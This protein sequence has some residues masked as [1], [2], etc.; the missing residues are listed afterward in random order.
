MK[1][2]IIIIIIFLLALSPV[3][4]AQLGDWRLFHYKFPF[5]KEKV[6]Y[7]SIE[8]NDIDMDGDFDLFVGNWKGYVAY[9]E[10]TGNPEKFRFNLV[11]DGL[12]K[13]TSFQKLETG[14]KAI[15]RIVDID[16]DGDYDFFIGNNDG[17]IAFYRNDG[18]IKLPLLKQIKDGQKQTSSYFNINVGFAAAPFFIDI[19]NDRDYDLFIGNAQG[20][21]A[22]YRNDGTV[23]SPLFTRINGGFTV[24]DSFEN[25]NVKGYAV[26]V[27]CD[28]DN[29]GKYD[30]FVGN[31]EGTIYYYENIGSEK[32][33]E[34]KLESKKFANINA[35]GDNSPYYVD[36][37]NDQVDEIIVGN[38]EGNIEIFKAREGKKLLIFKGKGD[39]VQ[40]DKGEDG[41]DDKGKVSLD[42]MYFKKAKALYEGEDYIE[43]LN[44]FE[45]IDDKT[46]E[47]ND[48]EKKCEQKLKQ[49]I[50][51]LGEESFLFKEVESDFKKGVD[52]YINAK[53][54]SAI[55]YFKKV[56]N[57]V[58]SHKITLEYKKRADKKIE[59]QKLEHEA[60]KF[61]EKAM[62]HYNKGELKEAF[63]NIKKARDKNESN[64]KYHQRFTVISND[65]FAQSNKEFYDKNLAKA[66]SLMESGDY[67]QAVSVLEQINEKYPKD[68]VVQELIKQCEEKIAK[69][70]K[71]HKKRMKEKYLSEGDRYYNKFEYTSALKSYE[72][73]LKYSPGDQEI[74]KKITE[75]KKKIEQKENRQLDPEAVKK[76]F[77]QGLKYY[78]LGQYQK[79]IFEWEKVLEMDP[80]HKMAKL[81][82]EKAKEKLK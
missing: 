45:K 81:N 16:S 28:I 61:Y 64:L 62:E 6:F 51:K 70:G 4:L 69:M 38:N 14:N 40:I 55:N 32:V 33:P 73:A 15:V 27:F 36:L 49:L 8:C 21:V 22:Y 66:K 47:M 67:T 42:R 24:E 74:T 18:N 75:T 50:V 12:S 46:E 13:N 35:G 48:L 2:S 60:E 44:M 79:A 26:P 80:Q 72:A 30:L 57:T 58:P 23:T 39:V 63:D 77:Q 68:E 34:F 10:N 11:N 41:K 3:L 19:D 17:N 37:N 20:F 65:Y 9:Y 53:Y 29:D 59:E 82:I 1:K 78:S 25:I 31:L 71:E 5:P 76:H 52:K 56:L 7:K 54:S 43:A